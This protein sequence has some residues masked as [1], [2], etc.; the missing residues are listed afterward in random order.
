MTRD[1]LQWLAIGTAVGLLLAIGF[2]F[3][4]LAG[5]TLMLGY[6]HAAARASA[7]VIALPGPTLNDMCPVSPPRVWLP[8]RSPR[9]I[10][11]VPQC[12][13]PT[14]SRNQ[15]APAPSD[16]GLDAPTA[17]G[18]LPNSLAAYSPPAGPNLEEPPAYW[19]PVDV[20]FED[21]PGVYAPPK[22]CKKHHKCKPATV[23]F[24]QAPMGLLVA[25]FGGAAWAARRRVS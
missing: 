5:S 22:R 20:P 24:G 17:R 6:H 23:S 16:A 10:H 12:G 11:A 18:S 2:L 25:L 9:P 7:R 3:G 19:Q 8:F 1:R 21:Y 13:E 15:A 14:I 4:W